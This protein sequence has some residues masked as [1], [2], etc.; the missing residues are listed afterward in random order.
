MTRTIFL[1]IFKKIL[2]RLFKLALI[3][4][5]LLGLVISFFWWKFSKGPVDVTFA[6]DYVLQSMTSGSPDTQMRVAKIEASWS[7]LVSPVTLDIQGIDLRENGKSTLRVPELSVSLARLPLLAGMVR[8]ESI[9]VIRPTIKLFRSKNDTYHLLVSPD[10]TTE[11]EKASDN[12]TD[13]VNASLEDIGNSFFRGGNLPDY[14][15]LLPL[16]HLEKIEVRGAH[17]IVNDMVEGISWDVPN[18]RFTLDRQPDNFNLY[19]AYTE[20]DSATDTDRTSALSLILDRDRN[21]IRMSGK[22]DRVNAPTLARM[23]F[24]V[25]SLMHQKFDLDGTIS[26]RLDPDWTPRKVDVALKSDKGELVLDGLSE[27]PLSFGNLSAQISYDR[28]KGTLEIANTHLDLNGA[29][30]SIAALKDDKT[31]KNI[32][33]L[34]LSIAAFDFDTLASLW[35]ES[36]RDT[37]AADWLTRRLSKGTVKNL[38]LSIP[39]DLEHPE[40]TSAQQI[41]AQFDFENLKADYRSPL[42]PVENGKGTATLR[43]DILDIQVESGTLASMPIKKG[44]VSITHLTHPTTIG[45]VDITA[46]LSGPIANV[47]S[48]IYEEPISLRDKVGIDPAGVKGT[49]DLDVHVTFPALMD[50]PAEKVIVKAEASLEKTLFPALVHGMDLS[51]GPF[52]LIVAD[53]GLKLSGTGALAGRPLTLD[54][55]QYI[56]PA[57]APFS[58]KI[59]ARLTSDAEIREKFGVN[60]GD[61][62]SGNIP[63]NIE[64]TEQTSGN[65]DISVKAD[66]TQGELFVTPL[67]YRKA[68][69]TK[70]SLSA[71]ALIRN[72]EIA[73][74]DNLVISA[75]GN[76]NA[77]GSITFGQIGQTWDVAAARFDNVKIGHANDFSLDL[78]VTQSNDLDLSIKGKRFDLR[79]FLSGKS[80]EEKSAAS[81]GATSQAVS[82]RIAVSRLISG[83]EKDQFLSSPSLSVKTTK[84]GDISY[85]DLSGK[86]PSGKLTATLKPDKTGR[87]ALDIFSDN[88]GEALHALDLYDRMIGGTLRIKGKQIKGGKINDMTGRAEI[89]SFTV[90]RAPILAKFINLFSLSGLAELL[91]NKGI[92]FSKLKTDFE[93]KTVKGEKVI[94][95]KNG[96]TSGASIGLGF[97]G[98]INQT[99]NTTNLEGTVVPMSQVNGILSKVPV[100]GKIL[101]GSSGGLI[102]A[103][104]TMKGPNENPTVFIN[105]L[106]VLTPGFLR[107]LL[108]ENDT[109]GFEDEDPEVAPKTSKKRSYNQ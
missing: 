29:T 57:T 25:G 7:S 9:S 49:S 35:P 92:E 84:A 47:L 85:L 1:V 105:P 18:V 76:V 66:L 88:A 102:A 86:T 74:V 94:F 67:G 28:S 77:K 60:I 53:G 58:S 19:L 26:G 54:Y 96:R 34:S 73:S 8:P 83:D 46:S 56:D 38:I 14:P 62:V 65:S 87:M 44:R 45:D 5:I 107:S 24:P 51:G 61:F 16:A 59:S 52:K 27:K 4:F 15:A 89:S 31:A 101:G 103:T 23:F 69:G 13:R 36:A 39:L 20:S 99:R 32:L 21:G 95:L 22:I 97:D 48:Y 70:G 91:Q 106:S 98:T 17:I 30:I 108:F 82:A 41:D 72:G 90:V 43:G 2:P 42:A 10:P 80:D 104:Y 79:P 109:G 78:K 93:W 40:N 64:Y 12:D 81:S 68:P 3:L 63:V 37:V 33:P 71:M 6:A 55:E 100:L 11:N 75:D 50:L